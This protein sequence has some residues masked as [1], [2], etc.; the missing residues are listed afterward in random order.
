MVELGERRYPIYFGPE[1]SAALRSVLTGLKAA[2]RRVAVVTD[3]N[4]ARA[5]AAT[6]ASFFS[7]LPVLA[8]KP[9]EGSKSVAGL[10]Q[11]LDFLA[12]EP[13]DRGGVVI[14]FGGGI[15][16]DLAGFAAASYLRGVDYY[17]VPTTLLAMVDSSVGGKTGINLTAGKNL[18]GAFHQPKGVFV[19]TEVLATLPPREFA[20]GMAE[21]IKCG[22][23]ADRS[24]FEALEATPLTVDSP[25]LPGVI[26]RCCEIKAQVVQADEF[27]RAKTGGRALLNL[28]HTFGH[29]I[30]QVTGYQLYL[31]GEAVG[32]GL[33]AA[34]RLSQ[35]L[36]TLNDADCARVERAVAAHHLPIRLKAP[37]PLADL[38]A[39][40]GR[41]KKVRAGALRFVTL[42]GL[43][44]AVT[45]DAVPLDL[46]QACFREVGAT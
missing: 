1:G 2:G 43:G 10:G 28:G 6:L 33:A 31:H 8:V 9:G 17:Q 38:M 39:A 27:E 13:L 12:A 14:A 34:A 4:A 20:A 26:R 32:I 18:A 7:G 25:A 35:K 30:E 15:V 40:A 23:L 29:A 16:G 19:S 21:V 44:R 45:H 24:L 37:L 36:G 3:G 41:D 5:Q 11:V 22:L 42:E 46:V